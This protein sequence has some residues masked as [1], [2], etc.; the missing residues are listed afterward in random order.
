MSAK[1]NIYNFPIHYTAAL[2]K[3]MRAWDSYVNLDATVKNMLTSLRAVAELQNPSLRERHWGQL[4]VATK[5]DSN[6][7]DFVVSSRMQ[8]KR[9]EPD[10]LSYDFSTSCHTFVSPIY[11][12]YI[13]C[14]LVPPRPTLW[15]IPRRLWQTFSSSTSTRMR[16]R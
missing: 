15:T 7:K 11:F 12:N 10:P 4:L 2:D 5:T 13:G 6:T 9:H 14:T 3:E 16:T 1:F 8:L